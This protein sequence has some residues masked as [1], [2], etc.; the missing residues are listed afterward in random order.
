LFCAVL[1][2]GVLALSGCSKQQTLQALFQKSTPHQAYARQL[3]Q[4][5][6]DN[7]PAGRAWLAAADQA[8]RDSLV[9][10]LPFAET[11]YFRP[12]RPSAAS[13]R[14]AVRAGEQVHISLSLAT[15]AAVR[16]FLDAF[17]IAPGRAP[18]PLASADTLALDFRYRAESDGQH[19]LRL[20]PELLAA[21]R[22]TLRVNREPS[23]SV[24]PVLG[25][26]NAAVGS[27][28]GAARDAGARQHEGIDIFA[29]RGTPAVAATA[30]FITR[31]GETPLGGRVV[32][33]SDTEHGN[34]IYYAH[35]DKQLVSP[36]QQVQ[37]GDTL[38]L[39]GNTGNARTTVPHLHFGIYRSG[40]GAVDPFPFVR[41]TDATPAAP[42]GPDR[43]GEFVRLR[44][45]ADLRLAPTSDKSRPASAVEKLSKQLPLL[46]LGQHGTAL[47]VQTPS[48]AEGYVAAQAVVA[49][50][51]SPLRRLLLPDSTELLSRPAT[52][53]PASGALASQTPVVVLG[54]TAAYSL[55]LGP[56][57]EVGWA[58]L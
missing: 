17:E 42:N 6:L 28:W 45:A 13:Y 21:G 24:F 20:Q 22:Y 3:H 41:R 7:R 55:L 33:L 18:V 1:L 14:Y 46:V 8:L 32:W 52:A 40:Q 23:L 29:K 54:Q 10:T 43:R 26:G 57:G 44:T 9:V 16:V 4:A 31:T 36:G 50:E 53:A 5:G 35:L 12:E 39:V 30:G 56:G 37:A 58:I 15:G 49:A 11:G 19:L 48:G 51:K 34:H 27:F 2:A 38:G 25:R 47:R